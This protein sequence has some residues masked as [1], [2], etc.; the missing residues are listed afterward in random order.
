MGVK[1][2]WFMVATLL[3]QHYFERAT[4]MDDSLPFFSPINKS[5]YGYCSKI[6]QAMGYTVR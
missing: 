6:L 1:Y 3:Q 2:F 4:V 5:C